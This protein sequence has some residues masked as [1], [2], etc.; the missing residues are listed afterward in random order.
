MLSVTHSAAIGLVVRSHLRG[1]LV[2]CCNWIRNGE[3]P[4]VRF[5][6]LVANL[7]LGSEA[8]G[9]DVQ[10]GVLGSVQVLGFG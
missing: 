9:W 5:E 10:F 4:K 7:A 3:I 2:W 8:F 1:V 6:F